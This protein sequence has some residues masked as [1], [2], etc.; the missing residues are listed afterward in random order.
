LQPLP[1]VRCVLF[2]L[3]SAA[4]ACA[5]PPPTGPYVASVEVRGAHVINASEITR[6]LA[7]RP[8]QTFDELE[9]DR[10]RT[11]VQRLY[12]RHGYFAARV[13]EAAGRR[14]QGGRGVDVTLVVR[15]GEPTLI[16]DVKV[17][18]TERLDEQTRARIEKVQLGLPRGGIFRHEQYLRFKE[19]LAHELASAHQP[20][21]IEGQVSIDQ[22]FNVA[23]IQ[24]TL[25]PLSAGRPH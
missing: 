2:L 7:S 23:D 1:I 14:R 16:G 25:H 17:L 24:I 5:H 22:M 20:A 15:E 13:V 6:G 10:D 9:L 4:A 8:L 21:A 18:G 19:Q 12:E 3:I 11:R